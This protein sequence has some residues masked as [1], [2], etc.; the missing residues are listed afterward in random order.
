M[1]RTFLRR[2]FR[3]QTGSRIFLYILARSVLKMLVRVFFL[4]RRVFLSL[5]CVIF[6]VGDCKMVLSFSKV[7]QRVRFE[8]LAVHVNSRLAYMFANLADAAQ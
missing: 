7:N 6:A 1:H 3:R 8:F 2:T 4:K 5:T